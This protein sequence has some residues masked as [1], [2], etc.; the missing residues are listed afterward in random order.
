MSIEQ[1]I[2]DDVEG[3]AQGHS[4]GDVFVLRYGG[5][6]AK[7]RYVLVP[8]KNVEKLFGFPVV[9]EIEQF[10]RAERK[11][12]I[13][14]EVEKVIYVHQ[15]PD[16]TAGN[17]GSPGAEEHAQDYTRAY[18]DRYMLIRF[19]HLFLSFLTQKADTICASE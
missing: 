10:F 8:V 5:Q 1:L 7:Q 11:S 4:H 18:A 9:T 12:S 2:P 13:E 3:V 19:H 14:P 16:Q 17:A 6:Q 15:N